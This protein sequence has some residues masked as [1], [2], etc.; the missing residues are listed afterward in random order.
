[1]SQI[2]YDSLFQYQTQNND[3]SKDK[4]KIYLFE[5]IKGN[6]RQRLDEMIETS[7]NKSFYLGLKYEYGYNVEQNLEQAL[8]LY[9]KGARA[10]STDLLSMARLYDMH[11]TKDKRF[12]I[13]LDKNLEFIYLFKTFAYLPISYLNTDIKKNIF[14]FDICYAVSSFVKNNDPN[15]QLTL[16][17]I[18][19]LSQSDKYKDILSKHDSNLI[20]GFMEG[21][22]KYIL[23]ED[24]N[25]LIL[26]IAL[27]YG[28]N[29]EANCRLISIYFLMLYSR[30]NLDE[31]KIE[32]IKSKIYEQFRLIEEAKYYKAYAQYG[33]FLYNDMRMFDEAL[34]IFKEGYENNI[35]ECA[36]YYFHAFTKSENQSIYD[37]NKFHS[38]EF[39]DI[40]RILIDAFLYGQFFSIELMFDFFYIIGKRYNLFTQLSKNYMKYL[41]EIALICL[42]FIDKEKG[43][44]NIKKYNPYEI[45]NIYHSANHSLAMIYMYGSINTI[46]KNLL[47]AELCLKAASEINEYTQPYYTS[48]I[49]KIK[50]KLFNLGVYEDENYL[51]EF[52]K[53]LFKLYDK[54]KDY[55]YYGN[56]FYYIFGK[57]YE[58][59]IGTNKDDKKAYQLY[60]RGCYSLLSLNDSFIIVYKRY[61]SLKKVQSD[62]FKSLFSIPN[63]NSP[64]FDLNFRLSTGKDI[65]LSVK[66]EMTMGDV[67]NELYKNNE[68]QNLEISIFLFGGD[69]LKNE[70]IVGDIKIDNNGVILV[71]VEQKQQG[72]I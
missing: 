63:N 21:Y 12:D 34:N 44:E 37:I 36:I 19:N 30:D 67:K 40:F 69:Q 13:I 10:N 49:Y 35:Y 52:G 24:E 58:K 71:V 46:K 29:L 11:K 55:K 50:K 3:D 14:P 56:S 72:I 66:K 39:I 25:S 6:L 70:K 42:S 51:I 23:N 16:A 18:D 43:K 32:I 33:L 7:E 2:D 22:F 53:E 1:M 20:K 4:W 28:G 60:E 17:Y 45:D 8:A 47:K 31:K 48:L 68:L 65:K 5:N 27:S 64:P 62:K 57:L 59:G 9:K 41:D 61:L 54:Y 15:I 38:K 26:L